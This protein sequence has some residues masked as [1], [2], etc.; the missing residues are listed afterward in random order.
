METGLPGFETGQVL[1]EEE[2]WEAT[3][4][5]PAV[6]TVSCACLHVLCLFLLMQA[7]QISSAW[8]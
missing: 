7:M 3:E 4:L 2:S 8:C 1:E 5:S 6:H